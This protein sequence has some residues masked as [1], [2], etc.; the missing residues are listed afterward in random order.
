MK[1]DAAETKKEVEDLIEIVEAMI[2]E[3]F[4]I[5]MNQCNGGKPFVGDTPEDPTPKK[6]KL[7]SQCF[8][9]S[10]PSYFDRFTYPHDLMR[11]GTVDD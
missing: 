11:T 4:R 7:P 2:N 8:P 5:T 9:P 6:R 3:H 10:P 1:N